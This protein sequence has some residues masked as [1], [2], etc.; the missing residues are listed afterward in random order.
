MECQH[1]KAFVKR[2]PAFAIVRCV[3][4]ERL[5]L[6]VKA[7]RVGAV[8]TRIAE[9]MGAGKAC[10]IHRELVRTVLAQ[11]ATLREVQLRFAP[12]DAAAEIAAW[13]QAGWTSAPQGEGDLGARLERAFAEA[14]ASGAER[15]VIVGSDCPELK[16]GDVRTAWKELKSH[17]VVVGPAIDGGY[18]L[19]GLR[20]P[21][22]ELFR[23]IAWS[24]DQVLGQTLGRAKGKG[25]KIQLLRILSDVDTEADWNAYVRERE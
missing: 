5:I 8:K 14:F 20:A 9:T 13:L 10:E 16:S 21:H 7:A 17:D 12:D 18:W 22:A 25:L 4:A 3:A 6:F 15:V 2:S 23:D 19:I 11:L 24:S 1:A